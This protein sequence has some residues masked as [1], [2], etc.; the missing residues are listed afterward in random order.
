MRKVHQEYLHQEAERRS[1]AE[2]DELEHR[3]LQ[4]ARAL[5]TDT[6]QNYIDLGKVLHKAQIDLGYGRFVPLLDKLK[7]SRRTAERLMKI[8]A[9][10]RVATHASH[11]PASWTTLYEI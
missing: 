4:D 7:I 3:Y 9:D 2:L 10:D 6:V 11:L 1:N 8:A 5:L